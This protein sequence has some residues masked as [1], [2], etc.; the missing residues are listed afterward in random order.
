MKET[1]IEVIKNALKE[2]GIND[3]ISIELNIP[4]QKENGDYSTNVAMK[5]A[6]IVHDSPITLAQKIVK[7]NM[8]MN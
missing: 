6:S 4:K 3:D 8:K 2:I 5:L 7:R 1:L